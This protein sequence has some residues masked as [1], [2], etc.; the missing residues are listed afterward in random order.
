MPKF[1]PRMTNKIPN[2]S[3]NTGNIFLILLRIGAV[4]HVPVSD[5]SNIVGNVPNPKKSINKAPFKGVF[6][7]T[8]PTAPR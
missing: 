6:V 5:K 7:A 3:V 8:A 4:T 1:M 2:K